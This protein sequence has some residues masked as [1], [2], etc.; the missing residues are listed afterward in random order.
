MQATKDVTI[1]QYAPD[2][3]MDVA[4][5]LQEFH[6]DSLEDYGLECEDNKIGQAIKD[7]NAN[8]LVLEMDGKVVGIITGTIVD[9]PLQKAKIYQE[10]VWYV[11][12]DYRRYGLKLL[13]ELEKRCKDRGIT[14]II[15]VALG[16]SMREQLDRIYKTMGYRELETH[17]IKAVT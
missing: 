1:R 7:N 8:G 12:K 13:R 17:Y 10:I 11:S 3:F 2:D 9:Y 16:S 6:K 15:M 14:Q 5:L 4:M